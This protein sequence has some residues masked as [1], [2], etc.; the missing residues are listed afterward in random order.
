MIIIVCVCGLG[1]G[2]GCWVWMGYR[3]Y[4]TIPVGCVWVMY[5]TVLKF[6]GYIWCLVYCFV[7]YRAALSVGEGLLLCGCKGRGGSRDGRKR[8]GAGGGLRHCALLDMDG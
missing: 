2:V 8:M 1:L 7:L 5:D 3:M 6:G 4:H